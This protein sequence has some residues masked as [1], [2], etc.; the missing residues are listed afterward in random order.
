MTELSVLILA[1]REAENLSLLI[2]QLLHAIGELSANYEIIV[3]IPKDEDSTNLPSS[4][5]LI[6]IPEEKSGYGNALKLGFE[7]CSGSYILTIDADL[8]HPLNYV[9]SIW[10]K[11][12]HADLIV[13]SRYIPGG[14][15]N[16]PFIRKFSSK[17]LNYVFCKTLLLPVNDIS[18]GYRLY[19]RDAIKDLGLKSKNFDILIEIAIKMYAEKHSI[20]EIPFEYIPRRKGISKA[21]LILFAFSYIKTYARMVFLRYFTPS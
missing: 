18:S 15:A 13:C 8:S 2:P 6:Y 1:K 9:E 11:K 20:I 12:D 7:N 4:N 17:L 10:Q 16:M 14:T 19:R 21:R 5:R 3:V